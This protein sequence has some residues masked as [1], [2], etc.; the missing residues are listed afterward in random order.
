MNFDD[1]NFFYYVEYQVYKKMFVHIDNQVYKKILRQFL[2]Q[3]SWEFLCQ[4][5]DRIFLSVNQKLPIG[6]LFN[7]LN[8]N[9]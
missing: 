1:N 3:V 9:L 4:I 2:D 7:F 8:S 6:N 5:E